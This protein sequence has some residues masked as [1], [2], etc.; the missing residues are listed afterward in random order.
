MPYYGAPLPAAI[1]R[2]FRNYARF[3][4]RSSRAEYWWWFAVSTIVGIT[5]LALASNSPSAVVHYDDGSYSLPDV[6]PVDG[7]LLASMAVWL[8]AVAIPTLALTVRRLH[9][10]N[11]SGWMILLYFVPIFGDIIILVLMILPADPQGRRFDVQA[12]S[13]EAS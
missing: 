13:A 7:M 12:P 2:F 4:G 8:L 5:W 6:G 1:R 3:S 11:L 10:A 9:D